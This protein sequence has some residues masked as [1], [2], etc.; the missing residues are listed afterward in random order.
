MRQFSPLTA[1]LAAALAGL[2]A[3]PA[4]SA[5]VDVGEVPDVV[6]V[7]VLACHNTGYQG[8]IVTVPYL[9]WVYGTYWQGPYYYVDGSWSYENVDRYNYCI[10]GIQVGAVS[11]SY[12]GTY[13]WTW[14][15]NC[16]YTDSL[17]A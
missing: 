11:T 4:A 6:D 2:F 5:N 14:C 12:G 15:V 3:V 1:L 13:Y 10:Y 8:T 7:D 16:L 9:V 17:L